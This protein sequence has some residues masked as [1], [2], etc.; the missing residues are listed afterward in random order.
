MSNDQPGAQFQITLGAPEWGV[1][2]ISCKPTYIEALSAAVE[3]YD[4]QVKKRD[5]KKRVALQATNARLGH[6]NYRT[7]NRALKYLVQKLQIDHYHWR[8]TKLDSQ[9]P[10]WICSFT[11]KGSHVAGTPMIRKN[12]A[13]AVGTLTA[14]VRILQ[15]FG[16]EAID[17]FWES[18]GIAKNDTAATESREE[19]EDERAVTRDLV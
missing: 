19:A 16:F 14:V 12:D 5:V 11:A 8:T 17:G 2:A 13:Q 9:G 3:N 10:Q 1:Q 18:I 6:L 4:N 7:S 15:S